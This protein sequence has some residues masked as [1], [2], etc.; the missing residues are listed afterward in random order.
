MLVSSKSKHKHINSSYGTVIKI[1]PYLLLAGYVEWL[2]YLLERLRNGT[3]LKH[4]HLIPF[5]HLSNLDIFFFEIKYS[6][7]ALL[8][9]YSQITQVFVS[10]PRHFDFAFFFFLL[11]KSLCGAQVGKISRHTC[12]AYFAK[13][14]N[15]SMEKN[16]IQSNQ[17]VQ[18]CGYKVAILILLCSLKHFSLFME[19]LNKPFCENMGYLLFLS[20]FFLHVSLFLSSIFFYDSLMSLFTTKPLRERDQ[21]YLEHLFW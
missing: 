3:A 11:L 6:S 12:I 8:K 4:S 14:N 7:H 19:I 10:S 2:T 17:D 1:I 15:G 20:S 16:I 18:V 5:S 21:T 9:R 13:S